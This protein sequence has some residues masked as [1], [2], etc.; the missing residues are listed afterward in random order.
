VNQGEWS[1]TGFDAG[2]P[3]ACNTYLA[4]SPLVS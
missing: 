4:A 1:M 3:A 2:D